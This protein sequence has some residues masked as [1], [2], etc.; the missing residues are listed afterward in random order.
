MSIPVRRWDRLANDKTEW[1]SHMDANISSQI[2]LLIRTSAS[3]HTRFELRDENLVLLKQIQLNDDFV[4]VFYPFR[5]NQ[6][7]IK[8][9]SGKYYVY[10]GDT[11][12]CELTSF[13]FPCGLHE[14]GVNS[15]IIGTGQNELK[16]YDV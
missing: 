16:L 4:D 11:S 12:T 13:E 5:T 14:Y 3:V 9:L 15:L 7:F 10:S 2:G 6:W 1:I 8:S